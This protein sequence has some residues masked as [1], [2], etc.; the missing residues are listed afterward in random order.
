MRSPGYPLIIAMS[1][2]NLY[3]TV[4]YQFLLGII[5]AVL[6]YLLLQNLKFSKKESLIITMFLQ[7]F[8][9]VYFFETAILMESFV[10]FLMSLVFYLITCK[11]QSFKI[12]VILGLVF[13]YLV[14]TKPFY[15]FIPFLL[16]GFWFLK[17]PRDFKK[18]TSKLI[19]LVI[20]CFGICWLVFSN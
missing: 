6:W 5:T 9:N 4:F 12:N 7:T 15:L 17:E 18:L 20:L 10:L 11:K 14:L 3:V 19:V 2:G 8:I 13:G 16:Y 1:F